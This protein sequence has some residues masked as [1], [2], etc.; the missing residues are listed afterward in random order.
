[1]STA[2]NKASK[3]FILKSFM[4]N[5]SKKTKKSG[6]NKQSHGDKKGVVHQKSLGIIKEE[7]KKTKRRLSNSF[8]LQKNTVNQDSDNSGLQHLSKQTV[9]KNGYLTIGD[10]N[11]ESSSRPS[12]C[13]IISDGS[14]MK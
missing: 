6:K 8:T 5:D 4:S 7:R 14:I 3:E 13:S 1:M 10:K 2:S 12:I 9:V 11:F